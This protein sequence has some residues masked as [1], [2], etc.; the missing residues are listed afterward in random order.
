MKFRNTEI[1]GLVVVTP[2]PQRDERGFFARTRDKVAFEAHGLTSTFVQSSV[3]LSRRMWTLRGLHWQ[4][5][6]YEETK[7]VTCLRGAVWDVVVDLRKGSTTRGR[8]VSCELSEHEMQTLHVPAGCAHGFI[9]LREGVLM[10][11]EIS[12]EFS[13]EHQKGLRW[14]DPSLRI[15]WPHEPTVVSARDAAFPDYKVEHT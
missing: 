10:Q 8:W 9:T 4:D 3:S 13:P 6:P 1:S 7:L 12:R 2:E 5:S 11:Y 15:A 14:N